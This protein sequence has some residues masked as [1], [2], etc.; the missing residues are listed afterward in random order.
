MEGIYISMIEYF[1]ISEI[2]V[3]LK[4]NNE[5]LK[6][7]LEYISET[8]WRDNEGNIKILSTPIFKQ[9]LLLQSKRRL[10]F[11][12]HLQHLACKRFE[13]SRI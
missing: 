12:Q 2:V 9:S 1:N 11:I 3:E 10:S 13:E 6:I 5:Q 4:I 7:I 8:I